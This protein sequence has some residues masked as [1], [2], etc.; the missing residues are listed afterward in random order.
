MK[1]GYRI[2]EKR[3][4]SRGGW[5]ATVEVDSLPGADVQVA[6][7]QGRRVRQAYGGGYGFKWHGYVW[8]D[9][10]S[11][12]LNGYRVPGSLGVRGLLIDSELIPRPDGYELGFE[13]YDRPRPRETS[14]L[15][16]RYPDEY[17]RPRPPELPK[18]E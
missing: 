12:K 11:G 5:Q 3:V 4:N 2:V 9:G 7:S 18:G 16:E 10:R 13:S 6:I 1:R 15:H 14:S 17:D 8:V